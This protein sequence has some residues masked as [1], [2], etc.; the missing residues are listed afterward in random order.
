MSEKNY[1]HGRLEKNIREVAK[2]SKRDL[3]KVVDDLR[4]ELSMLDTMLS[5]L[6]D[7]LED[8]GFVR[9][10]EYERRIRERLSSR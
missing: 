7:I 5:C 10:V 6:V 3:Q 8:N 4:E 1:R 2:L 9:R